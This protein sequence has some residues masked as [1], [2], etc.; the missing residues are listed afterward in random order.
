MQNATGYHPGPVTPPTADGASLGGIFYF[1][2][3]IFKQLAPGV[4]ASW[5]FNM[6]R[7]F[8]DWLFK[9]N[10]RGLDFPK[11]PP[12]PISNWMEI[13]PRIWIM[14]LKVFFYSQKNIFLPKSGAQRILGK[15][16][17]ALVLSPRNYRR[18][19]FSLQLKKLPKKLPKRSNETHFQWKALVLT[20]RRGLG[21]IITMI[22][23]TFNNSNAV[24]SQ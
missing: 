5:L 15:F 19:R 14:D 10:F 21:L 18:T 17:V 9:F 2:R 4:R 16:W 22:K 12:K 24:S 6:R 1:N 13:L 7:T 20:W 23:E 11:S 8:T 3:D